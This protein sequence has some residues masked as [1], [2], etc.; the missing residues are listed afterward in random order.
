M[1]TFVPKPTPF[2]TSAFAF[3]VLL[4]AIPLAAACGEDDA[5][6]S[7]DDATDADGGA[8]PGADSGGG[9]A[10]GE[11][12]DCEVPTERAALFAYLK[13]GTYKSLP[14]ESAV[15]PSGG[16]HGGNVRTYVTTDL[17]ASLK[18]GNTEHPKCAAAVKELYGAGTEQVTGYAVNV[19]LADASDNGRNWYFHET[20]T[21]DEDAPAFD[22]DGV[23]LCADCHSGGKDFVLTSYPLK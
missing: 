13:A 17:E 22:G 15:H 20:F 12:P 16:P 4:T 9:A 7:L 14:A 23:T 19:K 10:N 11:R 1:L 3:A 8:T 21:T 5:R 18:A 6:P 2:S